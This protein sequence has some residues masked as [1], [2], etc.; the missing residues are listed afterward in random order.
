VQTRPHAPQ[1]FGSALVSVH[2][3]EQLVFPPQSHPQTPAVQ[4]ASPPTGG[5]QTTPQPPQ[6]LISNAVLTQTPPQLVRGEQGLG[7]GKFPKPV[8]RTS[9]YGVTGE[10]VEI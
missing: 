4:V 7:G 10:S 9:T 6:L 5:G 1:F 8:R 2:T 3:F